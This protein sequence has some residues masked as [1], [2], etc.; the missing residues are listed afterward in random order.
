MNCGQREQEAD[1]DRAPD[2]DLEQVLEVRGA[3]R[4]QEVVDQREDHQTPQEARSSSRCSSWNRGSS[5]IAF[6]SMRAVSAM[7]LLPVAAQAS[8]P[9]A[10]F[11]NRRGLL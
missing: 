5:S 6:Q 11:T 8:V 10:E 3:D 7:L 9:M 2:L 4:Q 1:V